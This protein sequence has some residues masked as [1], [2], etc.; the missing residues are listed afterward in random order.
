MALPIVSQLHPS[1][2]WSK[3]APNTIPYNPQACLQCL[4]SVQHLDLGT[5][6]TGWRSLWLLFWIVVAFAAACQIHADVLLAFLTQLIRTSF[7]H[8]L[9]KKAKQT[10]RSL[11]PF[12]ICHFQS[13][14]I[15]F[16]LV[17]QAKTRLGFSGHTPNTSNLPGPQ[18][19]RLVLGHGQKGIK[20]NFL[21]LKTVL[22][23]WIR[24]HFLSRGCSPQF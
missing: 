10:P 12:P 7:L 8:L 4:L 17:D 21:S 23:G 24:L 2:F 6:F 16:L 15:A 22:L 5:T 3:W 11:P 9:L 14:Y 1:A 19:L 20:L 18:M 13:M